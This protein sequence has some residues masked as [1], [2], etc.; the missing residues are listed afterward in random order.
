MTALFSFTKK[1][2]LEQLRSYKTFILIAV[3]F[4]FG[5]MSPLLAKMMPD[6]FSGMD[7]SG[8]TITIPEPTAL[9]AY[10]QFFKNMSQMG[11][12][13]LLL[14]FGGILSQDI[15]K[16]TL[17]ILLAKGLPRQTVIVSK[18]LAGLLLWTTAFILAAVTAYGYTVYLFGDAFAPNLFVSMLCLWLFG[19]FLIAVLLLGGALA[20]GSYGGLLM[21]VAVLAVLLIVNAFPPLQRWNPAAL[22]GASGELLSNTKTAGDVLVTVI[23]TIG[24]ILLS[25]VLSILIFRRKRL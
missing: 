18:F 19:A 11:I 25:L 2:L 10:G 5:M 3:L 17:V 9:D 15:S 8:I 14:I 4:V 23:V 6:I 24:C 1:E 13:A 16:G 20:P 21:T 22:A 7:V 12:A